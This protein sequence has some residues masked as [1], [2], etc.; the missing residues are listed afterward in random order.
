MATTQIYDNGK[1]VQSKVDV[2]DTLDL[3]KQDGQYCL[4]I[5]VKDGK[6]KYKW[7]QTTEA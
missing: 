7:I 2:P 6:A 5:I 3:P 1:L 4:S